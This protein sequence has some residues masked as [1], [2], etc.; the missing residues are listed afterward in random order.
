[1]AP[2]A[3]AELKAGKWLFVPGIR[4]EKFEQEISWD[5]IN[6]I[7]NPGEASINENLYLP[8]LNI[9]Y[10]LNDDQNLRLAVS[11][12]VSF[13]EFKEMAPY[14]YEGVTSRTGGNPDLLGRQ[15][16]LN[17][18]NIKDVSYSDILNLDLKYEWFI[19]PD[20]MISI[21][22]F[23]KQIKNPVNLVVANDATGTQR[24]FRTG[25]KAIVKGVELE[26]KKNIVV[27]SD[28]KTVLGAG[29]NVAYMDTEQDL[30]NTVSGTFSTSFDRNKEEL[31]G[32]SPLL[33]NADISYHPS[34]GEHIKA[35]INLMASYF[36]DRIYALGSGQLGNKIEKGFSTLDLVWKNQIGTHFEFNISAK[37]LLNPEIQVERE[38][39]NNKSVVIKSYKN[40]INVGFQLKYKF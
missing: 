38:L 22:G 28:E 21:A 40:G 5:V 35:D 13:P 34:F 23:T 9:K 16:G 37:N 2:Y 19:S 27:N 32:A 30:F 33:L 17:Y 11:N 20:E 25:N 12:T 3:S 1:M 8:S 18:T 39:P 10:G 31:Q 14:V 36:S 6:L 4:I 29:I 7:N 15:K 24:F 26:A